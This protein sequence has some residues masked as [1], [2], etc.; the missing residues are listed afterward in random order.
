[1]NELELLT[2]IL[3]IVIGI[4]FFALIIAFI[5]KRELKDEHNEENEEDHGDEIS[6]TPSNLEEITNFCGDQGE[7]IINHHL[8]RLIKDDEYF[9]NNL[10]LPTMNGHKTEVDAVL[11]T[12]KGIYCVESKNWVGKIKGNNND[13]RWI[14]EYDDRRL[15]HKKHKNPV[16]Q[17]ELH[18]DTIDEILEEELDVY[19][20]DKIYQRIHNVV[21][22][23]HLQDQSELYSNC[24]FDILDFKEYYT[25]RRNEI[26]DEETLEDIYDILSRFE[27][28]PEELEA[29]KR[30]VRNH[31]NSNLS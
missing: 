21:I 23:S 8:Q 9:L 20:I 11:I 30:E 7:D 15:G 28:T 2:I 4:L 31:C 27:A 19:E 26:D 25:T 10:L 12:H 5:L 14:Q 3:S 17:N 24:T 6:I 18:C 22:F 1:M 13:E 29:H 16:K